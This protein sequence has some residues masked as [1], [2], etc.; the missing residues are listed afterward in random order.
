VSDDRVE[1]L[2]EGLDAWNRGELER[3]LEVLDPDVDIR[4]SGAFP[5]LG[6]AYQGHQ[7]FREF[8]QEFR[9]MWDTLE[10]EPLEVEMMG[11]LLFSTVGF[12]GRGRDGIEVERAFY[13]LWEFGQD[14]KKVTAYRAFGDRDATTAA[15][16]EARARGG[17]AE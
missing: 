15:A 6:P 16:D 8:W 17:F 1:L 3:V 11:E 9:D 7:G 5:G 2:R 14:G 4:L 13:F 12:R 10:V